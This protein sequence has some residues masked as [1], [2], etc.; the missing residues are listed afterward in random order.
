MSRLVK[1][2]IALIGLGV[3][4]YVVAQFPAW[5]WHP[6]GMCTGNAVTVRDCKG[7]NSWSG[8][9]SDFGEITL[10]VGLISGS[11]AARR[12][13]H[14]HFECHEEM[15]HRLGFHPVHGTPFRT[16]WAHHPELP[17]DQSQKHSV[18]LKHIHQAHARARDEKL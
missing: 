16:C 6:L 12:F 7:Y 5:V 17:G 11:V 2:S 10:L 14:L 4:A 9:F 1:V 13:L 8:L 15:C 18:K 3:I